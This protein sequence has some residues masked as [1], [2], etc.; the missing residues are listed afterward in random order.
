VIV[1]QGRVSGVASA[2]LASSHPCSGTSL[3]CLRLFVVLSDHRQVV[4]F[5]WHRQVCRLCPVV[6]SYG[7]FG[8]F[9][10]KPSSLPSLSQQIR[11][12]MIIS[13][14]EM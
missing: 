12:T 6:Q 3:R 5:A 4:T 8:F 13:T 7:G 9:L 10:A 1:L 11:R 2:E 14:P